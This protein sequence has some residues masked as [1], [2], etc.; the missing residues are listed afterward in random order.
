MAGCYGG[1]IRS[2][3]SG[4]ELE[5]GWGLNEFKVKV[6]MFKVISGCGFDVSP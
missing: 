1:I 5:T 3:D 6:S 4:Q 2:V